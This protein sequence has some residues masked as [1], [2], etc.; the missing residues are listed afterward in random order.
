[1]K[2]L[3]DI[4]QERLHI[5]KDIN[6]HHYNYHPTSKDELE[7]LIYKQHI[8]SCSSVSYICSFI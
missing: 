1:M 5:N 4:I 8:V 2:K 3:K 7:K 6:N